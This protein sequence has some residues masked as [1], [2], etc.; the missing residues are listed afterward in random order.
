[1]SVNKISVVTVCLNTRDTIRLTLESVSRQTFDDVEH[2][3][4]DGGSIDGTQKIIEEYPV[5]HFVSEIDDGVYDAMQKGAQAALGDIVIFLNAG[6]VFY[7][8][9]T[10]ATVASFFDQTDADIVFGNLMPV[11]LK[12]SDI[13]DHGAFV[14]GKFLDISYLRNRRQ[15]FDESIHHQATFYRSWVLKKCSYICEQ[16]PEASGE[17]NV[18]LNAVFKQNARVKHIPIPVSRFVLGGIS[19]RN[20][21]VEWEKYVNARNILRLMYCPTKELIRVKS[22]TEFSASI[23]PWIPSPLPLKQRVKVAVKKS[24]VFR[25]YARVLIGFTSRIFNLI[26]PRVEDLLELQTQRVFNDL[27]TVNERT[28]ARLETRIENLFSTQVLE[29][30]RV[31]NDLLTVNERTISRLETRIKHLLSIQ[32]LETQCAFKDLSAVYERTVSQLET[33]GVCLIGKQTEILQ[34]ITRQVSCANIGIAGVALS[35]NRSEEFSTYGYKVYSQWDEDG[36]I[37]HLITQYSGISKS[38]IEIGVGDYSEA[39]TR[40]LLEK[41]NWKGII[42]DSNT[43]YINKIKSSELYWRHS[44]KALDIFVNC[45]NINSII[46][47]NKFLGQIGL[48]SIDVDGID[49]WLWKVIEVVSP[50]IVICEYNGIFGSEA[51]VTVPYDPEFDRTK[52]HYSWLY[53]GASLAALEQLASEKGYTLIGTNNGGNNAFFVRND[54]FKQNAIQ[55]PHQKYTKPMFRESRTPEGVLSYLDISEGLKLIEDMDIYDIDQGEIV[56]IS[57]ILVSYDV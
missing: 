36:L 37:Q 57:Q 16:A 47:E 40:L 5:G 42:I 18:L 21:S 38:F 52:K 55:I 48:L 6:D 46:L 17:Y 33:L 13:H 51:R 35:V 22:E 27:S 30:Q 50:Q 39:N 24:V 41:N 8:R 11:Y 12:P 26:I 20:F 49:Y 31:F 23:A 28:I 10:C 25:I 19:T 45:E 29:N 9:N 4:I 56:K 15:L 7:D 2:V 1:M 54:I 3:I 14:A 53:A 43:E 34:N 32:D 44:L